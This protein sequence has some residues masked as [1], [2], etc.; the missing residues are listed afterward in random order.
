M[1][2]SEMC[3]NLPKTLHEEGLAPTCERMSTY[4]TDLNLD[5]F[6]FYCTH[7]S[8]PW[9]HGTFSKGLD[10]LADG[11]VLSMHHL[12]W[13]SPFLITG[14]YVRKLRAHNALTQRQLVQRGL[15]VS[16]ELWIPLLWMW[17]PKTK[18]TCLHCTTITCRWWR[19]WLCQHIPV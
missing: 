12:D 4:S 3:S 5:M 1:T 13:C 8:D 2:S 16:L 19:F 10:R 9:T 17:M 18:S 15:Q 6:L 14:P 7:R 11:T